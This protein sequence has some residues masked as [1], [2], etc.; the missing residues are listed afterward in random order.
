MF[1]FGL[2]DIQLGSDRALCCA[3]FLEEEEENC[4][5]KGPTISK[6][7]IFDVNETPF[8]GLYNFH[9]CFQKCCVFHVHAFFFYKR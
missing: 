3:Q 7:F 2:S 8:F 1:D 9:K 5:H 4:N 6:N